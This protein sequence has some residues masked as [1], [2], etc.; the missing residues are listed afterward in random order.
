MSIRSFLVRQ[1]TEITEILRQAG[2][3]S[4]R[5]VIISLIPS[6]E[7]HDQEQDHPRTRQRCQWLTD[8]LVEYF[9]FKKSRDSP[10]EAHGS[11][12][13][14]VVLVTTATFQVGLSPPGETC[15]DSYF[16]N[17]N[18]GTSGSEAHIART[19]IM[20]TNSEVTFALFM[21]FNSMDFSMS[22]FMINILTSKFPCNLI[23]K[24]LN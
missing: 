6:R 22:L 18:N 1:V 3:M 10:N 13:I 2:P 8:N 20:G 14:I 15:Q 17:P 12:L 4:A 16:S 23:K 21:V 7:S 24:N 11:L 19:S 5:D 9:K